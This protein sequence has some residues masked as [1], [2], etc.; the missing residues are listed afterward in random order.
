M[1]FDMKGWSC[2]AAQKPGA[3]PSMF[4]YTTQDAH[5]TVDTAGYFD[6]VRDQLRIGDLIYVTVVDANGALQTAGFHVVK[7]KPANNA[8]GIDVANVL[9]ATMTDTD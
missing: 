6:Q 3:A 4:T 5:A 7:D 1:A 2:A 9:A 8:A